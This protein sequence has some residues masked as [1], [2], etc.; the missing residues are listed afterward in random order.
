MTYKNKKTPKPFFMC[1]RT[2]STILPELDRHSLMGDYHEL[3]KEIVQKHGR[4][5]GELWYGYQILIRLPFDFCESIVWSIIMFRNYLKIAF[6]NLAKQKSYS[7]INISGLAIGLA[8]FILAMLYADFHLNFD[9][10]HKD[11]DKIYALTRI[12]QQDR[13]GTWAPI[14]MQKVLVDEYPEMKMASRY[15]FGGSRAFQYGDK[16]FNEGGIRYVDET[17]FDIFSFEMISGDPASALAE[18]NSVVITEEIAD[19]YFGAENP[20]GKTLIFEDSLSLKVTG[21][22]AEIPKNSSITYNFLISFKT[23]KH[24]FTWDYYSMI[25]LRLPSTYS[26]QQAE[27]TFPEIIETHIGDDPDKPKEIYLYPFN[28]LYLRPQHLS[29]NFSMQPATQFYIMI[30]IASVLLIVVCINFMN[31]ATARYL[32]RAR[33]VGMRK[34]VGAHRTQLIKQ[35]LGEST[36]IT[37]IALPVG[38]LLYML[39]RPWFQT[40]MHMDFDLHVWSH[41]RLLLMTLGVSALIGLVSGSYPAFFLSGFK[42][43]E[44]LRGSVTK[45]RKG[46]RVRKILVV[47][48]FMLSVALIV[49]AVVIDRQFNL[50]A[51]VEIGFDRDDIVVVEF[52]RKGVRNM[53]ALKQEIEQHADVV[54]V[55]KSFYIPVD[56]GSS[57]SGWKIIPEGLTDEDAFRAQPYPAVHDFVE[58]LDMTVLKGRSFSRDFND[59]DSFIITESM[60]GMLPWDDPI[61]RKITMNDWTGTIIGVVDNF[62]FAHVFFELRPALLYFERTQPY[63][64]LVKTRSQQGPM[65]EQFIE[66]SWTKLAASYPIETY[67]LDDEAVTRFR[68]TVRGQELIALFSVIAI[69]FSC[70]GLLGLASFTVERKTKE[71]AIRKVLGATISGLSSKLVTQ[72]LMLVGIANLIAWPL[73]YLGCQWFISWAWV[74]ETKL[75]ID[76]FILATIIS[77]VTAIV[78]VIAQSLK[79]ASANPVNGLRVE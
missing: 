78:A 54:S 44:I 33:E 53:D 7:L 43:A 24:E 39:L 25:F 40:F 3:Y 19:K 20:M 34:V 11:A 79:A 64:L 41:P 42:S 1:E 37:F 6:R 75:G 31:L 28:K 29:S 59:R 5:I 32:N 21:I 66:D 46:H 38:L 67:M 13:H 2:L 65:V 71:I 17:F 72:F 23:I 4:F 68:E 16:I 12:S 50:L 56:W 14:P 27:L 48:Q 52:Y 60:A 76:I 61:G 8:L 18:P 55:A 77:I 74:T 15:R 26:K 49:H 10:F 70:L 35:F 9:N 51:E 58:T 30:G 63:Y 69:I 36:L 45:S 73:A 47:S 57:G 62:H 22:T